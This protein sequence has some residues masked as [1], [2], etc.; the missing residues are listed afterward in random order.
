MG[1]IRTWKQAEAVL[2]ILEMKFNDYALNGCV[3]TYHNGRENG[4]CVQLYSS[5]VQPCAKGRVAYFSNCKNA[6]GIVVYKME[7]SCM[8]GIDEET[9]K[10]KISFNEEDVYKAAEFI[11]D[12]LNPIEHGEE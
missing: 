5:S 12:W 6:D 7:N 10:K 2:C 8:D 1:L 3:V 4:F 11:L 9:Y